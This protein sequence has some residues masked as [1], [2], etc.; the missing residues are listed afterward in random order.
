MRLLLDAGYT[1]FR[2]HKTLLGPEL[3]PPGTPPETGAWEAPSFLATR[4]PDRARALLAPRGWQCLA[5][6]LF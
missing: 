2:L 5:S 4:Q 6:P 3:A 1:L